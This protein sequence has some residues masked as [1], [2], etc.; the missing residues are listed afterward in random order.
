MNNLKPIKMLENRVWRIYLGGMLLDELRGKKG[1]DGYFPEDWLASVVQANNPPH[2]NQPDR[3][4]L[5]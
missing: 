2:E 4:G 3:E 1:S 5:S